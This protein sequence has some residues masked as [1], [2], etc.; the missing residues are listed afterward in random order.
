[1]ATMCRVRAVLGQLKR[2]LF[3]KGPSVSPFPMS[4]S[5]QKPP[6]KNKIKIKIKVDF[7]PKLEGTL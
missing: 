3:F 5:R 6:G 7:A 2:K 4:K 1:M